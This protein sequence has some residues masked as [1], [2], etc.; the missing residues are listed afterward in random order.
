MSVVASAL[1]RWPRAPSAGLSTHQSTRSDLPENMPYLGDVN[2]F[3]HAR[4]R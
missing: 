2:F 4:V 3:E 1:P